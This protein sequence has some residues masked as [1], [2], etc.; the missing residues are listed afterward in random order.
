MKVASTMIPEDRFEDINDW[1]R[2]IYNQLDNTYGHYH[3]KLHPKKAKFNNN[4][5]A[6]V[7]HRSK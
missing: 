2:Y 1:F 6:Q 5:I 7:L 3:P 4:S